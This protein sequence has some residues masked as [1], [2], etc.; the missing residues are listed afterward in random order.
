M[1]IDLEY[2][3]K[4]DIRNNPVVRDVDAAQRREF[5]GALKWAALIVG[6]LMLALAPRSKVVATG[7]EVEELREQ[8]ARAQAIQ[9]QYRLQ[10]ETLLRPEEIER[11]AIEELGMVRPNEKTAIVR[12]RVPAPAPADRAIVAAVRCE[13]AMMKHWWVCILGSTSVNAP[14]D[15]DDRPDAPSSGARRTQMKA[16]LLLILGA[17]ALGSSE[18]SA[19]RVPAGRRSAM[20]VAAAQQNEALSDQAPASR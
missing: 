6:I 12:D 10:L 20:V 17:A 15:A 19:P 2:A 18:S 5:V 1:S 11:R 7:Y 4:H 8:V 14:A 3:I 9:R 13:L 16:R